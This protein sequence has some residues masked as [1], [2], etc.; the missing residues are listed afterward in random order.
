MKEAG[1]QWLTA[2]YDKLCTESSIITNGFS[3]VGITGMVRKAR[4]APICDEE[5]TEDPFDS[6]TVDTQI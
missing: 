6:C 3:K 1:A 4:E 5:P 2:L